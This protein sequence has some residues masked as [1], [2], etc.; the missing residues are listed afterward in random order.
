[1]TNTYTNISDSSSDSPDNIG[2]TIKSPELSS[3]ST[4]RGQEFGEEF[5]MQLNGHY[6][7][8]SETRVPS[9]HSIKSDRQSTAAIAASASNNSA[10]S[11]TSSAPSPTIRELYD[12]KA[13]IAELEQQ[14][15][16]RDHNRNME[17]NISENAKQ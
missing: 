12:S 16:L 15:S 7:S 11:Y 2:R 17:A 6:R 5:G 9:S 3:A 10:T 8:V 4:L 14:L 13:R 1:M